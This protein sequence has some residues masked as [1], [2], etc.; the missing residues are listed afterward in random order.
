MPKTDEQ[1]IQDAI[2]ADNGVYE[3]IQ[4]A[5]EAACDN[6]GLDAE[7]FLWSVQIEKN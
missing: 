4:R 5:L 1:K 6:L 2:H 3:S 7:D